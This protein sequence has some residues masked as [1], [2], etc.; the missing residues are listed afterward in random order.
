MKCSALPL[1]FNKKMGAF[2]WFDVSKSMGI[3]KSRAIGRKCMSA[4]GL[5]GV[6]YTVCQSIVRF[7]SIRFD[8]CLSEVRVRLPSCAWDVQ[9]GEACCTKDL[10]AILAIP[11]RI[12]PLAL[13]ANKIRRS[14]FWNLICR[15]Q[16]VGAS[17][18]NNVSKDKIDTFLPALAKPTSS[19]TELPT[20]RGAWLKKL[21]QY[22]IRNR[23]RTAK[24][25]LVH[26]FII[27]EYL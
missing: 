22:Y 25:K 21:C 16:G 12:S 7:D 4:H 14:P 19:Y 10:A 15:R 1:T 5:C 26:Q 23:R 18:S 8:S 3:S 9:N 2:P 17:T 27:P 20:V 24:S 11:Y 6:R 13:F